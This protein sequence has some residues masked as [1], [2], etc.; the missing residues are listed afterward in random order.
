M[1]KHCFAAY[2]LQVSK[3]RYPD[4]LVPVDD[5]DGAGLDLLSVFEEALK[6][7]EHT[8]QTDEKRQFHLSV[9]RYCVTDDREIEASL[10]YGKYGSQGSVKNVL[11]HEDTYHIGDDEAATTY[12]RNLL[13]VP[14]HCTFALLMTERYQRRGAGTAFLEHLKKYTSAHLKKRKLVLKSEPLADSEAFQEFLGRAAL[15]HVAVV[16][17]IRG[18]DL[19]NQDELRPGGQFV[20]TYKLTRGWA[21]H[22]PW[23]RDRLIARQVDMAEMFHLRTADH[24]VETQLTLHDGTQSRTIILDEEETAP[25]LTH[26]LAEDTAQRPSDE[27]AFTRMR[28]TSKETCRRLRV[29]SD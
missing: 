9:G 2:Q 28:R 15:T 13:V 26:L 3:Q 5:I 27:E 1:A 25:P 24:I 14:P 21:Q 4:Q 11:S 19:F 10:H 22:V 29:D 12:F 23:L 20:H 6:D 16:E 8:P 17:R 18:S 7:L